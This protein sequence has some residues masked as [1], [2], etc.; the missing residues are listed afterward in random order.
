MADHSPVDRY[1][2]FAKDRVEDW[3]KYIDKARA[4][5][6]KVLNPNGATVQALTGEVMTL[7]LSYYDAAYGWM[8]PTKK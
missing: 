5:H 4:V 7:G 8:F 2:D 6:K 3:N 1:Y